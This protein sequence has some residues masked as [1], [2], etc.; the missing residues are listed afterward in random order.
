MY[1][2][3][4]GTI[5]NKVTLANPP[6]PENV[7]TPF[8]SDL[9][10]CGFASPCVGHE[11]NELNLQ[12]LCVKNKPS[13]FF[14]RAQGASMTDAGILDGDILVIDR[15][16]KPEHG[17]IVVACVDGEFTVKKLQLYPELML[18]PCN[19]DYQPIR[20]DPEDLVIWGVVTFAVHEF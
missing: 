6:K 15:S 8:F 4:C 13:T 12:E 11:D 20:P 18:I 14:A 1:S 5:M 7:L 17:K 9:L 19:P 3:T 2:V 16:L 10:S